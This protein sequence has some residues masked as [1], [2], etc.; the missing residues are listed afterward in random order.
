MSQATPLAVQNIPD[1]FPDVPSWHMGRVVS[2]QS[3]LPAQVV[4]QAAKDWLWVMQLKQVVPEAH[5]WPHSDAKV[6]QTP[7]RQVTPGVALN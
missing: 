6:V 1:V 5:G 4:V 2:W 3:V 7:C